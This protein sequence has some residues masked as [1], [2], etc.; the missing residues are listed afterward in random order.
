MIIIKI[1]G[2]KNINTQN[3]AADIK[4]TNGQVV[5]VHGGNFYLDDIGQKLGYN[6]KML[7]LPNGITSRYTTKEVIDLMYLTYAGLMNKK[8]VESLQKVGVNAI[9]LSGIDGK[10][11]RGKKHQA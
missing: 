5:I 10:L 2:G 7:T 9:G 1:G 6:K 3:I 8:I 11:I 4:N